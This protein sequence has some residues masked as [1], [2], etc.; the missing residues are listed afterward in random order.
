MSV[1]KA[2]PNRVA[3]GMAIVLGLFLCL[4]LFLTGAK[5]IR[6]YADL[7]DVEFQVE[8]LLS[9]QQMLSQDLQKQQ[10]NMSALQ[11][12]LKPLGGSSSQAS[13]ELQTRLRVLIASVGGNVETSSQV[14]AQA[15]GREDMTV[16]FR[17]VTASVRWNVN[18]EGLAQFLAKS[19]ASGQNLKI[20]NLL[21]R[22]RQGTAS[23]LDIRMQCSALWQDPSL[24]EMET[25][26]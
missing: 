14:N 4:P 15:E 17:P 10:E 2:N 3:Q 12:N 9:Q 13:A 6:A 19:S 20:D 16:P 23:L 26:P 1:I 18:E 21:I 25:R 11:A 7:Q 22:R 5:T 8:K 24:A